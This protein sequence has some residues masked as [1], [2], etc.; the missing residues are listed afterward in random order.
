MPT[1][2][3]AQ[4]NVA[5]LLAPL[6]SP[7]LQGFVARLE[8]INALAEAAPGF[9]WRFQT[10]AGDATGVRPY[11]DDR[12]LV[13]FSVWESVEALHQFVFR[14]LHAEVMRQRREWFE[15]MSE[16]YT[17]LWWVPFGHR[18]TIEEA[19]ARLDELRQHG[20]TPVAFTFQERF[21]PPGAASRITPAL[22]DEC[23]A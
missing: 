18:P 15:R 12:I 6:D 20:P 5:R 3:L 16:P 4:L 10:P 11:A 23:P 21:G 9:V 7:Q 19:V 22:P 2:Q 17:V 14:T 8:A 13:N 1:P